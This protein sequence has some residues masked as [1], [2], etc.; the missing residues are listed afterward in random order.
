MGDSK[1]LN[2][3]SSV[4]IQAPSSTLT[5]LCDPVLLRCIDEHYQRLGTAPKQVAVG[6]SGGVDSAT[7]ALHLAVWA[8]QRHIAL[9]CFHVHHGLQD[10]ADGWLSHVQTLAT[11]LGVSCH[12]QRV[13][14]DLSQGDGMESAAR[15]ARYRAFEQM[16]ASTGVAHIFLAHHQD[17]QAE[18]VLLRLLRGS[19]PTGLKA[20]APISQR[21]GLVYV[22]PWLQVARARLLT[23]GEQMSTHLHWQ[24][25]NDTTNHHDDYTRGALRERL[26]PHLNERWQGWQK[27][28]VRHA[29]LS[30]DTDEVLTE[31]AEQDLGSLDF[32]ADD[33]SFGLEAWRALSSSRQ[34]LVLRHWFERASLQMPTEARLNNLMRQL[35]QLHALGFDR[36]M[37]V[38]HGDH[39][40]IC[41]RG[42]VILQRH[43]E[44]V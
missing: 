18:T 3:K 38:K 13:K 17:D 16:A 19:G 37:Q 21:R 20:M 26:S 23:I 6:L 11:L 36:Q 25:V 44:K 9:H 12:A 35:R 34:A 39:W 30:R 14:V 31:V 43:N 4:I 5:T 10:V 2:P 42:R 1:K 32:N 33:H 27:V 40:V 15:S 29:Q 28:L 41:T 22:R 8:A 24:A 7:L